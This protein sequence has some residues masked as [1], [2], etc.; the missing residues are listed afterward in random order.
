M[1]KASGEL[2]K[3]LAAKTDQEKL[4]LR[5]QEHILFKEFD[6]MVAEIDGINLY[7]RILQQAKN[8]QQTHLTA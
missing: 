4:N 3:S 6:K 2:S 1:L 8:L 5:V 7:N